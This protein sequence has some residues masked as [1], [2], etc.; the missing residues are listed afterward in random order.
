HRIYETLY[1][2]GFPIVTRHQSFEVLEG[3]PILVVDKWSDITQAMLD[4]FDYSQY[5]LEKLNFSY[6][7]NIIE[8]TRN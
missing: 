2:G 6:W 4:N 1:T 7:E 3:L 8:D 5:S